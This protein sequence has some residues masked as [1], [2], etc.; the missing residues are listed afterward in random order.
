M[1]KSTLPLKPTLSAL[2]THQFDYLEKLEPDLKS[3]FSP[4]VMMRYASSCSQAPAH[5]LL[6][7]NSFVN[8]DFNTL[9][10]H[11]ELQWKLLCVCGMGQPLNHPWIPPGKR[12]K[13]NPAMELLREAYPTAKHSDLELLAEVS[14]YAELEELAH[15][16]NWNKSDIKKLKKS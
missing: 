2:D 10:D 15:S 5:Y 1:S 12:G 14:T 16:F 7:V 11:P 9:R 3:A 6:M 13:K 8:V 4:W